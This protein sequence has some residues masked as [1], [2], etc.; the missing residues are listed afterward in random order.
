MTDLHSF[1]VVLHFGPPGPLLT[2]G[3]YLAPDQAS[4][5]ALAT[6]SIKDQNETGPLLSCLVVEESAENLRARLHV[7]EGKK[8]GEVVS[9]VRTPPIAPNPEATV[10][11]TFWPNNPYDEITNQRAAELLR[12]A[13]HGATP[14]ADLSWMLKPPDS[15]QPDDP[16]DPVA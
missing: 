11:P 16:L 2:C 6:A 15:W 10:Y 14:V 7:I 8:P 13:P 9:L 3:A 12:T 1:V 4:A 5:A